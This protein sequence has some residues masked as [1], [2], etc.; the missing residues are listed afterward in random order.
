MAKKKVTANFH[1]IQ[2]F[3]VEIKN[4]ILQIIE[5]SSKNIWNYYK[6]IVSL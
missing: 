1:N 3:M 5:N 6:K 2:I 4:N